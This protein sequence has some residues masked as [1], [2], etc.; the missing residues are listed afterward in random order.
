M[1]S[2]EERSNSSKIDSSDAETNKS[3]AE[4]SF[5]CPLNGKNNDIKLN[6]GRLTMADKSIT[7]KS[8]VIVSNRVQIQTNDVKNADTSF[9][10]ANNSNC[11]TQSDSCPNKQN[12]NLIEKHA[13]VMPT[14]NVSVN[15]SIDSKPE[16][17]V[18]NEK[19]AGDVSSHVAAI[20]ENS[21]SQCPSQ[22][23]KTIDEASKHHKHIK[24]SQSKKSKTS[25]NGLYYKK[26]QFSF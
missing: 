21:E 1:A 19:C 26:K 10:G 15:N 24:E 4:N 16:L 5:F 18:T 3:S 13:N 23:K 7:T 14:T 17:T 2:F 11:E 9:N 22:N 25:D 6:I 8:N 12:T 20:A